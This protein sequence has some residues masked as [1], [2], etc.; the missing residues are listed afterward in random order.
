MSYPPPFSLRGVFRRTSLF[1]AV[2]LLSGCV[3][4]GPLPDAAQPVAADWRNRGVLTTAPGADPATWWSAF[5][6]P[7]LDALVAQTLGSN[8][9]LAQAGHRLRAARSLVRPAIAQ[10]RPQITAGASGQRQQRLSGP[11]N[12]D[13][14]RSELSPDGLLLR[15]EGRASGNWQAGFDAAWEIDLFGRASAGVTAARAAAEGAEAEA[16]MARVSVVAEVVRTYVELRAAQQRQALLT[17]NIEAQNRLVALARERRDA[18][19]GSDLD[20]DR[21]L[22]IAADTAGQLHTQGLLIGQAVQRIAVLTGES[23]V[24]DAL[25]QAVSQPQARLLALPILPADL[26]RVRPDIRRAEHAVTQAAAELDVAVADLYPRLSLTGALQATGNLVGNALPGRTSQALAG[27]SIQI[28]LLDW[29]ARRAVVNAREAVLAATIE[30]YRL[31]VLEGI[32]ETENALNAI[33]TQ[34][35]RMNE[36]SVRLQAAQRADSHA[37]ML[38]RRGI[39]SLSDRLE[40]AIVLRGAE[41][42]GVE[43]VEQQALAVVAL[44]KAVGGAS[45]RAAQPMHAGI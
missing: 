34:R 33:E 22:T 4:L 26:L 39:T 42:A 14:Q 19:I 45:L 32:E 10:Q 11:G 38:N 17:A 21:S 40:A 5:N 16:E 2:A 12:I 1:M 31:A 28:P 27:L 37:D 6:D 35:R 7:V 9:N 43:V 8:L 29:G 23:V 13:L 15:E 36:E 20:V 3:T 44:H 18:G 24:N 30:S 41:L 25:L